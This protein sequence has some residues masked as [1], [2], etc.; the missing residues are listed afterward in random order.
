M[1]VSSC[2][3]STMTDEVRPQ[4]RGNKIAMTAEERDAF[5]ASQRTCRVATLSVDGPHN[6]A[7]WFLWD[8]TR[9][10]RWADLQRD[11]RVA[12]VIDTGVD[13]LELQGIEIL[14]RVEFVGEQPRTG[15]PNDD[16]AIME[17]KF[18]EK[19][20]DTTEVFHDGKHAWM[21]VKPTKISSWDFQKLTGL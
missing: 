2:E 3:E 13:Y 15:E 12:I 7:L 20:F 6:T 4:K 9:A 10:Q 8:G 1:R 11:P 17:P 18:F 19:Y 14:G 5:L 21:R 16:L